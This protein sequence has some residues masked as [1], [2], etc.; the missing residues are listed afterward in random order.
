MKSEIMITPIRYYSVPKYPTK[1]DVRIDPTILQTVPKRWKTKPAVCIAL[2]LTLST[3]LYGCVNENM[4]GSDGSSSSSDMT[5]SS[6]TTTGKA[7]LALLIPVFEHGIGRGS[8]GCVSVAPPVFLSEEEALQVIHEE[9]EAKGV[10]F[11][12]IKS[13]EGNNFP[14]TNLYY[15]DK[16]DLATWK[17]T[18]VLDGY[19][20]SLNIGFE[21]VSQADVVE[22]AKASDMWSSVGTYDMKGTSERLSDVIENTVV[23]YDPAQ[24]YDAYN[25]NGRNENIDFETYMKQ[26]SAEQKELMLEKL[27]EQVRDFL[28]WLA[29]EG[30]I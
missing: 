24:D 7:A 9:A 28:A 3:G 30:I 18:L 25:R 11:N 20:P 4:V 1:K 13:V 16:S 21:F 19:D 26:Y 14:A 10:Y 12:D 8:F 27:R 5:E 6:T 17:G 15:G 2:M 29:A 22:W 23:F